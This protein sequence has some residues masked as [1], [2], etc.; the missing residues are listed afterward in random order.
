MNLIKNIDQK[1]K[2]VTSYNLTFSSNKNILYPK[3]HLDLKNILKFLEE[4]NLKALIRS[5]KC[6]HGDKTI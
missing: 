1:K 2:K 5:G 3:N 6:G 4:E